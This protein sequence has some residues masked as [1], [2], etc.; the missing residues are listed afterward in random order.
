M[1]YIMAILLLMVLCPVNPVQAGQ[2]SPLT[3]LADPEKTY[4]EKVFN[5]TMQVIKPGEK[6]DWASYSGKGSIT[7]DS[8][9]VSKSGAICR[10]FSESFTVQGQ[11]G[12]D[13]G[14]GCK[15]GGQDGW[16]KLD[17]NKEA[18]TCSFEDTSRM[19]GGVNITAPTV[20]A[21]NIGVVGAPGIN[22]NLNVNTNVNTDVNT[23]VSKKDL[24]TKNYADTVTGNAG[25][26]AGQ[27][28]GGIVSWFSSTFLR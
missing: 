4:Y 15:R 13:K 2:V 28:A 22:P 14:T 18:K 21:P 1:R 17:L 25:K 10:N 3:Y 16:C 11:Q 27:A 20:N 9:F 23:G 26:G 7:V 8:V 5:Y 12:I 6:Y 19:F 24:T